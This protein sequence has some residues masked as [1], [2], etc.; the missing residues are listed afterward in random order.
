LFPRCSKSGS[1][2]I[3]VAIHRASSL[4]RLG[5]IG[6]NATQQNTPL[7]KL[8]QRKNYSFFGRHGLLYDLFTPFP[9]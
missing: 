8:H 7:K 4:V 5:W 3:L 2:T 1:L 9:W 6:E